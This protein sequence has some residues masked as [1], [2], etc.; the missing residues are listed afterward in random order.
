MPRNRLPRVK[1]HYTLTGRSNHGRPLKRL[2]DAWDR[3]GSTSG[4]TAWQ[5]YD[6]DCYRSVCPFTLTSSSQFAWITPGNITCILLRTD[7]TGST[8]FTGKRSNCLIC[9]Q[10]CIYTGI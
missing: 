9:S 8:T 3:N 1:K 10:L 7:Y 4:P 5:I 2:L 6:D